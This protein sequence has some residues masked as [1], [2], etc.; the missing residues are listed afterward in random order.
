MAVMHSKNG[1]IINKNGTTGVATIKSEDGTVK[2]NTTTL[3]NGAQYD[4]SVNTDL[5]ATKKSVDDVR[6][7]LNNLS[8]KV[9]EHT[10]QIEQIQKE[11]ADIPS[12]VVS[13]GK[14]I[15]LT[16]NIVSVKYSKGLEVN[17][18][19]ELQ[20]KAGSGI[21]L[22][23]DG[24]LTTVEPEDNF[25]D[26][27]NEWEFANGYRLQYVGQFPGFGNNMRI[28]YS[29]VS[30]TVKFISSCRINKTSPLQINSTLWD[31]MLRYIGNRF[32]TTHDTNDVD[33]C[34][35]IGQFLAVGGITLTPG[36]DEDGTSNNSF[37]K[38]SYVGSP[39]DDISRTGLGIKLAIIDSSSSTYGCILQNLIMKV[40]KKV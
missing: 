7:D 28:L 8:G 35:S 10:T 32:Y 19:N 29:P 31:I 14:A 9:N 20:V 22:M 11:I 16:N 18:D 17:I 26:I 15:D 2:V 37:L 27:T 38:L 34:P 30:D 24:K 4:L 23:S 21:Y 5:I 1:I 33:L 39:N 12:S 3:P 40:H 36:T 25:I 6:T 13:A